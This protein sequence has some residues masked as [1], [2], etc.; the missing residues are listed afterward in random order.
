MNPFVGLSTAPTTTGMKEEGR[1]EP[2]LWI[3]DRTNNSLM[4]QQRCYC[5]V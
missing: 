2:L 4:T 1:D 5:N 3:V